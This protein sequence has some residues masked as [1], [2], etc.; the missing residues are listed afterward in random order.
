MSQKQ[1]KNSTTGAVR[2]PGKY[3]VV[4]D[5]QS[6]NPQPFSVLTGEMFRVSEKVD[7][8]A[9]NPDWTWVWATDPHGHSGWVPQS[10][11]ALDQGGITATACYT[12]TAAELTVS[13]GDELLVS[14]AK[15]GWAWSTD[16][17]RDN[18]WVPL[19]CL[20]SLD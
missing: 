20:V 6:S 19:E 16:Q 1:D 3:R 2:L 9:G 14:E 8:W 13:S 7:H 4:K 11:I 5:Y 10:L 17:H 12:Y 15:N 18:G